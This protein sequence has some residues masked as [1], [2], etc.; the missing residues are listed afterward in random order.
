MNE[1]HTFATIMLTLM[2][3]AVA[4]ALI[5]VVV[6]VTRND[7]VPIF[8]RKLNAQSRAPLDPSVA[9]ENPGYGTEVQVS[10]IL[11]FAYILFGWHILEFCYI[12]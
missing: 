12:F 8:I 4:I 11:K 2:A 5:F 9:F 10:D 7:S 6:C 3:I 1:S